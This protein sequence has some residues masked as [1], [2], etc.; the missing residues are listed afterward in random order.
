MLIMMTYLKFSHKIIGKCNFYHV[1]IKMCTDDYSTHLD[2]GCHEIPIVCLIHNTEPG[3]GPMYLY[4]FIRLNW[5][6][7]KDE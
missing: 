7:K 6:I 1:L 2:M 3:W 5:K 4:I